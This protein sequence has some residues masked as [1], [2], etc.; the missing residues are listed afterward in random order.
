MYALGNRLGGAGWLGV[1]AALA[2]ALHPYE[3]WHSQDFRNYALWAGFS[4]LAMW[5]GLRALGR[6]RLLDL[7]LY[8]LAA[9]A[10]AL[11]FY[12]ELFFLLALAGI[13]GYWRRREWHFLRRFWMLQAGVAALPLL[14]F[15]WLQARTISSGAYPG[16]LEAFSL[17]AFATRFVPALL[18]GETL[19]LDSGG[20]GWALSLAL[21]LLAGRLLWSNLRAMLVI[22]LWLIVPCLLLTVVSQRMNV[23]NPRYVLA[24]SPALMLLLVL[25]VHSWA[26]ALARFRRRT[27]V[28]LTYSLLLPWLALALTSIDAHFNDARYQK[29]PAWDALGDFLNPLVTEDDLVIQLAVDAAF[30]YYYDGPARDIAL[31]ASPD[32][33]SAEIAA[34]LSARQQSYRSIYIVAREQAGWQNAGV[35]KAWLDANMQQTMRTMAGNLPARQYMNWDVQQAGASLARFDESVALL[36]GGDPCP[37][38]LPDGALLLR[39]HWQPLK[40]SDATLKTFAHIYGAFNPATGGPL[41]TQADSLPV[42]GRLD[43]ASLLPNQAFRQVYTMPARELPAG[44]YQLHVGW[45]DAA[46][47]ARLK[48]ADGRDSFAICELERP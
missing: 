47:G 37:L 32:Q 41:W 29:A 28:L 45:Y 6:G 27:T 3:I 39:L 33:S 1:L 12:T 15:L 34:E 43:A 35:V 46:S 13:A 14:S 10:A 44:S 42:H 36:D 11:T 23:F 9:A 17:E 19:P 48:L 25:G 40:Q 4:A 38:H 30:G 8:A 31:P 2:W 18:L 24:A 22:L 20:L 16:N 7:V 5:L 21:V 26:A